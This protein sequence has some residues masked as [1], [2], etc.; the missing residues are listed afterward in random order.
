MRCR[1]GAKSLPQTSWVQDI[2]RVALRDAFKMCLAQLGAPYPAHSW[3]ALNWS[4]YPVPPAGGSY[5]LIVG[6][7]VD[8]W[9]LRT[10]LQD[11]RGHG[12][13]KGAVVRYEDDGAA[14]VI[15]GPKEGS[16]R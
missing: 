1:Q 7:V 8:P 10:Q 11:L 2:E 13:Q 15:Q 12:P 5:V 3:D 16:F 14:V 4:A 9:T 6:P